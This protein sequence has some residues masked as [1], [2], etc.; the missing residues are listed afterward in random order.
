MVEEHSPRHVD[1][2]VPVYNEE[3]ILPEFHRRITALGLPLNILYID[4]CST[5]SSAEIIATFPG[6][7]LIKHKRN[8]GYGGSIL[9]GI[10]NSGNERI[11]IIDADCEYPPEALPELL[12]RLECADVVYTSRFLE[13][14]NRFMPF[15]KRL[16]NQLL[17]IFFNGLF[18]QNLTDLYTG[19]KGLKRSALGGITLQRKGFEHVLELGVK[20]AKKK[21]TIEEIAIDFSPRNTGEAKMKHFSET[22]KYLYLILFYFLTER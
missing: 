22:L 16:G 4:N 17:T 12:A 11:I 9:D 2:I 10:A 21:I 6:V 7:G 19:C 13:G 14:R 1:V 3:D 5:D 15:T 8:E 18:G 20:L